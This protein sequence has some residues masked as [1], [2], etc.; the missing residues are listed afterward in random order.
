[1]MGRARP[2][3]VLACVTGVGACGSSEPVA[4]TAA[5]TMAEKPPAEDLMARPHNELSEVQT[6]DGVTIHFDQR[7][8]GDT[9]VVLVHGWGCDSSYW[10]RQRD[11]LAE[12]YRVVTVDLAGH[13]K[14]TS[15]R[16][17]WSMTAFGEDVAAVA[18]LLD[19]DNMVLVGHSMGGPV[20]LEAARLLKDRVIGVVGADTLWNVGEEVSPE[21]RQA[22]MQTMQE[23]FTTAVIGIVENMF[24]EDADP[25][26]R[27]FVIRDM[28]STPP[29]VG[30]PS[31]MALND[32]DDEGGLERLRVPMV[33][34]NSDYRPN[35]IVLIEQLVDDFQFVEMTGVGHFVMLEDPATFNEHL[36][37]AIQNFVVN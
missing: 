36:E 4:E 6:A 21:R 31:L 29:E 33:L 9:T 5:T 3:A 35:H 18:A 25:A 7:G 34:I 26:I 23:D 24:L 22:Y 20:V 10:Q 30:I 17:N 28:A 19:L 15:N 1:M 32:Y 2:F 11:W 16:S 27:G 14:S 37:G 13:G 12:R 8:Q